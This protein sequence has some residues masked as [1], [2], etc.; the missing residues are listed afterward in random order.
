MLIEIIFEFYE[1]AFVTICISAPHIEGIWDFCKRQDSER[2]HLT[3]NNPTSQSLFLAWKEF[4]IA[5]E[6]SVVVSVIVEFDYWSKLKRI[7]EG[8]RLCKPYLM[9]FKNPF[10]YFFMATTILTIAP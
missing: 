6:S 4:P 1:E 10:E 9:V 5:C 2:I 7:I 8:C 3:L